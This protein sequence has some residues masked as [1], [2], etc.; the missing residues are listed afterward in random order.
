MK[1][2]IANIILLNVLALIGVIGF[3]FATGR[4]DKEKSLT[5]LDLLKHKGTPEKLRDHT[6][7]LLT[8]A[9]QGSGS[10]QPSTQAGG[11][12]A[13]PG[14]AADRLAAAG[15]SLEADRMKLENEAR[16]LRHRQ[17]LLETLQAQVAQQMA[18]LQADRTAYENQV[19]SAAGKTNDD[20]FNRSLKLY[21]EMKPRQIKEVFYGLAKGFS[22]E[23]ATAPTIP[24]P[25]T[26]E[27]V[28]K[29]LLAMDKEK[30]GKIIAEFKT[31]EEKAFITSVLEKIRTAT[32]AGAPAASPQPAL[33]ASAAVQPGL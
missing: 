28:A 12:P 6:Y 27:L 10:T 26:I 2:I 25:A 11:A 24:S 17:E 15:A 29:Y 14:S 33:S 8:A 18:K 4:I 23:A 19:K 13:N 9:T 20:A 7:E 5:I 3:L 1:K 22:P 16:E 21:A 32:P 30:A 31:P